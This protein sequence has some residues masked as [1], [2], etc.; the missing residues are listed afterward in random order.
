[1]K[2]TT[3]SLLVAVMLAASVPAM[4]QV[5]T[6]ETIGPNGISRTRTVHRGNMTVSQSISR[7]RFGHGCATTTRARRTPFGVQRSV[8]RRCH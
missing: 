5:T 7:G 4:A 6:S 1:M 2:R 8:V 3:L